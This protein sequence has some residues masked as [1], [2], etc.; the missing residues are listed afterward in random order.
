GIA[1]GPFPLPATGPAYVMQGTSAPFFFQGSGN[2]V[3]AAYYV[4]TLAPDL[5][6]VRFARY[7]ASY[8]PQNSPVPAVLQNI[9]QVHASVGFWQPSPDFRIPERMAAGFTD[10][11]DIEL[12]QI[13][14]DQ[15]TTFVDYQTKV[16]LNAVDK[17]P[18]ADLVMIY[19]EEPDGA[20]HQ[21]LLT[22]R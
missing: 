12:E 8:I 19:I 15:V 2:V 7:G 10:F 17:N 3:G 21:F 9:A 5:S 13:Y 18:D 6:A 14:E 20:S 22:E 1:P 11:S 4:T 16:A